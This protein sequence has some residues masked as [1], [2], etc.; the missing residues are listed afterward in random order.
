M[1]YYCENYPKLF[2]GDSAYPLSP[3]LLKVFQQP[4]RQNG[5]LEYNKKIRQIRQII[6]R[7]IGILKMR[8]RCIHMERPLRYSPNKVGHFV[9]T[10]VFLHNFLIH[11]N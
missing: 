7:V 11:N 6:E 3:W 9:Y 4:N 2:S 8:F 1:Q 10:C 5:E